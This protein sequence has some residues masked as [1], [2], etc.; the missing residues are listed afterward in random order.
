MTAPEPI[1]TVVA[2]GVASTAPAVRGCLET[3]ATRAKLAL[4]V[5]PAVHSQSWDEATSA[6]RDHGVGGVLLMKPEGWDAGELTARLAELER[7]AASGLVVAT[8][9]EGG[10]VQRLALLGALPSQQEVSETLEP[11]GAR[12]LVASHAAAVHAAGIDVV[13]GPVVDVVPPD[14]RVALNRSRFFTGDAATVAAYAA[15]YVEGWSANGIVPVLKHFPGHGTAS[16]DTHLDAGVT[17]P[18]AALEASDLVPYRSLADRGAAVMVGHLTVPDLTGD[19]PASRSVAAIE[20]LRGAGYGD[21]L[22]ISDA[23]GMG[24]VGVAV[25][26]AAV[27]AIAAGI[28]VAIFADT[29]ATGPVIDALERALAEGRLTSERIDAAARRVLAVTG[30]DRLGCVP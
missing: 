10:D 4:L 12:D 14:G 30:P 1:A 7:I 22:V 20:L 25:D 29:A 17:A 2:G 8:D 19:L 13:L 23:L 3:M 11:A 5:W 6:V 27:D 18:L 9:E 15:A 16:A 24:A 21:A 28:D 26:A